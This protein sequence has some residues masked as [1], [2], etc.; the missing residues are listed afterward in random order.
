MV[1]FPRWGR[2]KLPHLSPNISPAAK[3]MVPSRAE[4]GGRGRK[5]RNTSRRFKKL[6]K[7]SFIPRQS[8]QRK[9]IPVSANN[10]LGN[11]MASIGW[12]PAETPP[13]ANKNP[14]QQGHHPKVSL[15]LAPLLRSVPLQQCDDLLHGICFEPRDGSVTTLQLAKEL[16]DQRRGV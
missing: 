9:K 14:K 16:F 6:R 2:E 10:W 13:V 8:L 4:H 1:P 7:P 12:G 15:G 5:N 11:P 3:G